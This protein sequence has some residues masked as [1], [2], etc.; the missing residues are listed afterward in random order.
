[1]NLLV[2][3][4]TL[5]LMSLSHGME[6]RPYEMLPFNMLQ[7]TGDQNSENLYC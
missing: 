6:F 5:I 3:F 7:I 4:L 2:S 1:M